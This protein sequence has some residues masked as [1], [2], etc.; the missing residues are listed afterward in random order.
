M[1]C[2]T[3]PPLTPANP[4]KPVSGIGGGAHLILGLHTRHMLYV[5]HVC[6]E[7]RRDQVQ[8]SVGSKRYKNGFC[9]PPPLSLSLAACL[10]AS[11]CTQDAWW[12]MGDTLEEARSCN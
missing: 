8:H 11:P 3:P 6:V 4:K 1:G 12:R 2:A 7:C 5:A 9:V 10:S